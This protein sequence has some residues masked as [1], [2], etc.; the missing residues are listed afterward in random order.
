MSKASKPLGLAVSYLEE[1]SV[2]IIYAIMFIV[3]IFTSM[4]GGGGMGYIQQLGSFPIEFSDVLFIAISIP[5]II[6]ILTVRLFLDILIF[7]S[8]IP[9]LDSMFEFIKMGFSTFLF[10]IFLIAPPVGIFLCV[11]VFVISY[12]FYKKAKAQLRYFRYIFLQPILHFFRSRKAEI[13]DPDFPDQ[14]KN[15]FHSIEMA[16]QGISSA[17]IG[18]I[19]EKQCVWVVKADNKLFVC[20]HKW[21][22]ADIVYELAVPARMG[23]DI[24]AIIITDQQN[25]QIQLS[26]YYKPL[27]ARIVQLTRS[28][29]EGLSGI[30]GKAG[31]LWRKVMEKF[32]QMSSMKEAYGR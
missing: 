1:Y 15:H 10:V 23:R 2:F 26:V 16:V 20:H 4:E 31:G 7:V 11:V 6:V 13:V 18:E 25:I 27:Y 29:D 14:L 32:N 30:A 12:F 17:A 8:P 19:K 3:P 21:Y 5:V 9:L 22:T 28:N 24:H